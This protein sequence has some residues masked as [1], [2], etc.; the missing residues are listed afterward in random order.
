MARFAD[1]HGPILLR[2]VH[3]YARGRTH[4]ETLRLFLT[5]NDRIPATLTGEVSD[6][7]S[8]GS[9]VVEIGV[10][11]QDPGFFR[12]DANLLGPSGEPVAFAVF[13]G[14][15][16]AGRGAVPLEVYGKVL[17]DAGVHGPWTVSEIRGYR[18]LEAAY[19]DRERL[20]DSDL[21]HVTGDHPLDAFTDADHV[22]E[23]ELHVVSLM[24]ED[25]ER[26]IG[27]EVPGLPQPG[28]VPGPR[29]PDDDA[30]LPAPQDGAERP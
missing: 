26:G 25:V 18:F 9:L 22:D 16:A 15:L 24:L 28:E 23:H 8:A 2:V 29:P 3:E 10:D 27:L 30:E 4:E 14:E 1:H 19:P 13:K 12:F 5:P 17:R 21:R 7:T 20:P 11:V 6:F